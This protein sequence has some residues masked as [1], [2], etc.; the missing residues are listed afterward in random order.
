MADLMKQ[1]HLARLFHRGVDRTF[2][3]RVGV[4][5]KGSAGAMT[6]PIVTAL[7]D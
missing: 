7:R 2:G 3:K 4:F 6:A 1:R 5:R